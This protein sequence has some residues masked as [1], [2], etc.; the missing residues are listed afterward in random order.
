[1]RRNAIHAFQRN[2]KKIKQENK[3]EEARKH[4]IKKHKNE[5]IKNSSFM[6]LCDYSSFSPETSTYTR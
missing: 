2:A 4:V 6:Q 1:N 5:T 3:L